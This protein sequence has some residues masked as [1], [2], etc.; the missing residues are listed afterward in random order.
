MVSCI[1]DDE[2]YLNNPCFSDEATCHVSGTVNRYECR[3]MGS[4]N[5][6]DV[7]EHE[8]DSPKVSL[9]CALTNLMVLS[10]LKSLW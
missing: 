5:P 3:V 6:H 7:N 10:F 2:N 4:E 1:E 8:H 9:R